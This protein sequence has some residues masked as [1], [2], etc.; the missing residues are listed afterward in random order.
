MTRSAMRLAEWV[1]WGA[2]TFA[3]LQLHYLPGNYEE[4]LCGP[5]G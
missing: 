5:W 1:A 2:A 4:R 3:V